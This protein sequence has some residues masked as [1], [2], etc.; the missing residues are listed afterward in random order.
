MVAVLPANHRLAKQKTIPLRMLANEDFLLMAKQTM[1]HRFGINACE[2]S[3]FVPKIAYT[4]YNFADLCDL[5]ARGMG[6]A[7]LMKQL[8]LY[9]SNPEIAIVDITPRVATQISLCYL[10]GIELSAAA[11]HF[12]LCAQSQGIKLGLQHKQDADSKNG[13]QA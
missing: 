5:V 3:G 10:K 8:A 1:L 6:V 7:L 2:Q 11:R 12:V 4:D 13:V 9:V